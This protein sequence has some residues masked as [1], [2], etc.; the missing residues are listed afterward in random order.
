MAPP[1]FISA[2]WRNLIVLSWPIDDRI[3][4]P[5]LPKALEIDR[6]NGQTYVSLVALTIQN[7][8]LCGLPA[9]PATFPQLNIRCYVRRPMPDGTC[10]RGVTFLKQ[11]VPHRT[12][13]LAARLFYREPFAAIPRLQTG[14]NTPG[15]PQPPANRISYG[16]QTA[17]QSGGLWAESE[18]PFAPAEP[19]SL[20]DFLTARYWGYNSQ[21]A[22]TVREYAVARAAWAVSP[23]S[24]CGVDG[25]LTGLLGPELA[26]ALTG[27]PA[28]ALIAAGGPV[29]ISP[30]RRLSA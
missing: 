21:D 10:R 2:N 4:R 26:A 17:G 9:W 27:H 25:N 18:P 5:Q 7:L 12:T 29:K 14:H 30:P 11:L 16:W 23:A 3:I 13:A 24:N 22:G 28:T 1:G 19:D 8:R 20:A 6:C 15:Q